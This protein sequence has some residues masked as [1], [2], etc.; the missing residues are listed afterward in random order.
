MFIEC[1]L[2]ARPCARLWNCK[3]E[4]NLDPIILRSLQPSG[5]QTSMG[6][7]VEDAVGP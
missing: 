4:E 7:L 5:N 3:Q 1:L 2:L 6:A